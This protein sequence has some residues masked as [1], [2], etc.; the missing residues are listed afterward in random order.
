MAEMV[1]CPE[2][3]VLTWFQHN[4]IILWAQ[5][6][7]ADN[8]SLAPYTMWL[9]PS[10]RMWVEGIIQPPGQPHSSSSPPSLCTGG[11]WDIICPGDAQRSYTYLGRN[12]FHSSSLWN[13]FL[14]ISEKADCNYPICKK[15]KG[16]IKTSTD[17][18]TLHLFLH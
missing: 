12:F 9:G 11:N 18:F 14:D 16:H 6:S 13:S 5:G 1:G 2:W 7:T 8:N 15:E 4:R 10:D 3:A 17:Y